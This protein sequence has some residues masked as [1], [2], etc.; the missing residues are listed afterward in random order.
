FAVAAA[1]GLRGGC[2][3]HAGAARAA[4]RALVGGAR[5][6]RLPG[7]RAPPWARAGHR[8]M[9]RVHRRFGG[10]HARECRYFAH[11]RPLRRRCRGGARVRCL[12]EAA[13]DERTAGKSRE[14]EPSMIKRSDRIARWL[15]R[16]AVVAHDLA[17]VWAAWTG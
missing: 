13:G 17:M 8:R 6:A 2:L 5:P 10:V 12:G 3:A 4:P 15:P 7:G 16:A 9:L 1:G 14:G 11:V